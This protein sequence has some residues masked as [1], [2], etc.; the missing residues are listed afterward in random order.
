[1]LD[2]AHQKLDIHTRNSRVHAD[3]AQQLTR[4]AFDVLS[5]VYLRLDV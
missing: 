5:K 2:L 1:M 3:S 4:V